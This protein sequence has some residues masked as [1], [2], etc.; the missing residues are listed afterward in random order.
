MAWPNSVDLWL[1]ME[2]LS[3]VGGEHCCSLNGARSGDPDSDM[4]AWACMG[5]EAQGVSGDRQG[6]E[7]TQN[8]GP[9]V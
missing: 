3:G 1:S 6:R 5:R 2:E 7:I 4:G 8:P 9:M